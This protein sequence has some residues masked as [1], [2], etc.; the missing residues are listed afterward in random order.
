[1]AS[2]AKLNWWHRF[3]LDS[4]FAQTISP[5]MNATNQHPHHALQLVWFKRD[6]RTHDHS[7]LAQAAQRGVVLPL[8]VIED[9]LWHQRDMSA[10][11]W[12]FVAECL[13]DLR[14]SLHRIGQ[15][16]IVRRGDVIN[17]FDKINRALKIDALW[18]H[19][20]TGNDWTFQRDKRVS[21][22]CRNAGIRWHEI[23]QN[24]TQRH[25]KTRNGWAKNWDTR[26]A[27]PVT[28]PPQLGPVSQ[29]PVGPIPTSRDLGLVYD[30]C[31]ERQSGG[32]A[33][34]TERLASFLETRGQMYRRDMSSPLRGA[35]SCSRISP[36]LAWGVLSIREVAQATWDRQRHL[37][38]TQ[39]AQAQSWK[40]SLKSFSGRLHW[41]CHFIQKL[42]DEPRLEFQNLHRAYDGLRH[43]EPDHA[44]LSAWEN[45]ETGLPFVDACMRSLKATGWLNFRMR[46]MVTATASYHLWLDWRKPGEYLA[47]QFTD[48][49]PGIH[50]PQIQMQSG[51]TGINTIRIYNP[52]KQGY[53]QDPD[54]TFVRRWVPELAA[55]DDRYLQEPWTA[56]N[57]DTVLGGIYPFAVVDHL[58]AA[59]EARQKIWAVRTGPAFRTRAHEILNKH[60]SRKNNR[61][62]GKTAQK[63]PSDQL[64]F[65]FLTGDPS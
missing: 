30:P 17:I 48:Y 24:G 53:D 4:A 61:V 16:L 20:E 51:T 27:Q 43:S 10:R 23:Q 28:P 33:H 52:V 5:L 39:T 7:V 25:L 56:P 18:S 15:P 60:G 6:L 59:K 47:R 50:W 58:A 37:K 9:E 49:E 41:H 35:T 55:I 13:A 21:S 1:M 3:L 44:R 45:G 26:M 8:Y 12:D 63:P 36:Y 29:I 2:P 14:E 54:G 40:A 31:P 57:A 11:Q 22:W 19:E 62:T 34:A 65:S 46:A 38:Q 32:R 42:E 64:S